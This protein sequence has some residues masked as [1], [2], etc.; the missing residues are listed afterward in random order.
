MLET[1]SSEGEEKER[2][3]SLKIGRCVFSSMFN[4]NLGRQVWL[5]GY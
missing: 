4:I 1:I 5:K 2:T 3:E